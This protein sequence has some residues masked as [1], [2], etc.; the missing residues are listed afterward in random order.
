M[1]YGDNAKAALMTRGMSEMSKLG[2]KLGA[3]EDT[4][5]GLTG[6]GD[7]IVTCT[8]MHSR[9]R[10]CGIMIGEGMKPTDAVEKV[11]MVVEGI[12]TAQAAHD[13][14]EKVGVEML[15]TTTIHTKIGRAHV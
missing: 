10:R 3:K 15:I 13:L 12:F 8:S 14:A 9:N 2:V 6:M 5:A 7:L 1:G 11:G 4:F